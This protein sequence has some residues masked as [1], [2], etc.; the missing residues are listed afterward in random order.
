MTDPSSKTTL[1]WL[2]NG[3]CTRVERHRNIVR[4]IQSVYKLR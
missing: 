4:I 1:E 2:R 3:T